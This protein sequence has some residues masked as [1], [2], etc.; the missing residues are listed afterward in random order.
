MVTLI[1]AARAVLCISSTP[2]AHPG[3]T[4]LHWQDIADIAKTT[5]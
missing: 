2:F 5:G 1:S 3:R 4:K